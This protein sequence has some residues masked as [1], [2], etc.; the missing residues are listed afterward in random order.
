VDA[1]GAIF[2]VTAAGRLRSHFCTGTVVDSP[3]GDLV[4]TAA[5]C[6]AGR[7]PGSLAFVPGFRDGSAPLGVW[8]VGEVFVDS[9]WTRAHDPDH[10]FAFLRVSRPG[11]ASTLEARTGAER[12]GAGRGAGR[13]TTVVGYPASA[14]RAISCQTTLLE[15]SPT[16]LEF[17]CDGYSNGTSGSAL[18]VDPD[19]VT[20]LG[21]VVGAIGGYEQGG[22]TPSVSYA[23]A[24]GATTVALYRRAL[25]GT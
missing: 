24:F 13:L 14:D 2:T 4:L 23:A 12:L 5:H 22:A 8:T 19:P 18:V 17:D 11:S 9:A 3:G 1:V 10:D 15:L 20:G 25:R 7:Q 6:L 16:Q 21:T